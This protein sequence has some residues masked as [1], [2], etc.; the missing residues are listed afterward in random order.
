MFVY[1]D[2]LRSAASTWATSRPP[3]RL[4]QR[5]RD[6]PAQPAS[7]STTDLATSYTVPATRF[8]PI[9]GGLI[10]Y[11]DLDSGPLVICLASLRDVR[12]EYRFLRPQLLTAGVRVMT[13]DL[14]RH[15]ESSVNWQN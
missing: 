11:D 2:L 1:F 9:Q 8:L 12:A 4:D 7:S 15:G 13:L 10:A 3:L 14:R 6:G 5:H